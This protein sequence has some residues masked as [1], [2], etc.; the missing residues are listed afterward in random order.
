VATVYEVQT[1]QRFLL[2][3]EA[4]DALAW[5]DEQ[6]SPF[7]Q[8]V[9]FGWH[10]SNRV[11]ARG[12]YAVTAHFTVLL[13]QSQAQIRTLVENEWDANGPQHPLRLALSG[14]WVLSS[15]NRWTD[16]IGPDADVQRIERP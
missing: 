3:A 16:G 15:D 4:E 8:T 1:E 12:Y 13:K 5:M 10:I 9:I 7:I 2:L 11:P 14:S 6:V